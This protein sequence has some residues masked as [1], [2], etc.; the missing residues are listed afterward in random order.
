MFGQYEIPNQPTIQKAV[1]QYKKILND[2]DENSLNQ[3]LVTYAASTSTQIVIVSIDST[4]GEDVLFLGAQWA[5]KWGIGQNELDNGILILIAVDDRKLSINTGYG[6]E[7]FLTDARSKRIIDKTISPNFK[8]S[9][10]Y[11]GLN[12]ATDQI[13]EILAGTLTQ[14][15]KLEA[16]IMNFLIPFCLV[17][18]YC[19]LCSFIQLFHPTGSLKSERRMVKMSSFGIF[20]ETMHS[21]MVAFTTLPESFQAH[22]LTLVEEVV[23]VAA[24]EVAASEVVELAADGNH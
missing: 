24:S 11:Q 2:V 23:L 12:L 20:I 17:C 4:K 1:Y 22:F 6:V 21:M 13:I 16:M 7:E 9:E 18:L 14:F 19:C 8:K 10:Y 15:K 3:K 5:Q